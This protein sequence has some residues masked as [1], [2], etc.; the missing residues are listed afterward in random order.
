MPSAGGD[1]VQITRTGGHETRESMDGLTLYFVALTA[2][3]LKSVPVGGGEEKVVLP[4]VRA[5]TWDIT[6]EGVVYL[7]DENQA[8]V[9]PIML[10]NPATGRAKQVLEVRG[11]INSNGR[12]VF[13]AAE[14]GS[15]YLWAQRELSEVDLYMIENI[16]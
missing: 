5:G 9:R 12:R 4:D 10:W 13:A 15:G 2:L 14:D 6:R 1:S 16:R 11:Q 8:G 7:G 3:G